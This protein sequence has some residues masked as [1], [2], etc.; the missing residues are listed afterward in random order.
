MGKVEGM[1]TIGRTEKAATKGRNT[2]SV[3]SVMREEGDTTVVVSKRRQ[4]KDAA[5]REKADGGA[6][7]TR[8]R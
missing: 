1:T 2:N 3:V 5:R 8:G 4:K 7:R 6:S